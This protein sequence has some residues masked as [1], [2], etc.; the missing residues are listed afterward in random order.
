MIRRL[1]L[2]MGALLLN[3]CFVAENISR[4][5]IASPDGKYV[6]VSFIRSVG[7]TTS[8]SPQVSIIKKNR[9]LPNKPGNIFIGNHSKYINIYW[10]DANTLVVT[11]DCNDED[12]FKKLEVFNDINIE[13]LMRQE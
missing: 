12:I 1:I 6:A 5:T 4:E 8:F 10:K 13:Y 3:S 7:A 9:K 11:H 2:F